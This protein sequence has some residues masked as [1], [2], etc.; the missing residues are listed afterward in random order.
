GRL[1]S[2]Q[3]LQL[4]RRA[5]DLGMLGRQ[6]CAQQRQQILLAGGRAKSA[7]QARVVR[8]R[9]QLEMAS[10]LYDKTNP[11][12]LLG[13]GFALVRDAQGDIVTSAGQA[14]A[15]GELSLTFADDVILVQVQ[16]IA[17]HDPNT[18]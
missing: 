15:A 17:A 7:G 8:E 9:S 6:L 10:M 3:R 14:V 2:G 11:L 12:A 1:I 5:S 4:D 13:R 16:D 18:P